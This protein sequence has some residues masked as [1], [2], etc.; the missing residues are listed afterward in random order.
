MRLETLAV[1]AGAEVDPETGAVAP[2]FISPPRLSTGRHARR[3]TATP[4]SGKRTRLKPASRRPWRNSKAER[5]AGVRFRHGSGRAG[6]CSHWEPGSH[7][8]M[9]RESGCVAHAPRVC[10]SH[11]GSERPARSLRLGFAM[12]SSR[13]V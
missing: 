1:R 4:T 9:I 6:S 13:R 12:A 10:R 3:F 8:N 5:R 11:A 2:P 7:V